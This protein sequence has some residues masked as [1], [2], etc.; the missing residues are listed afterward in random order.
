VRE[1]LLAGADKIVVTT[2]AVTNPALIT[3]ISERFGAQCVV[4]GIDYRQTESG[5][6]VWIRCGTESTGLDPVAHAVELVR[7]GA[8]E[9]F[10]NSIDRDG[11]MQGY[12]LDMAERVAR[13]VPVPVIVS[14]GAGNFMHLVE[15]LRDTGASAAACASLF[16]F[17][18]N[19]P[20][21]A[22]SYI[23]NVGM[24]MRVLK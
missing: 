10:L 20:I 2:A 21:R 5:P 4:A 8:G 16:H 24:P 1:L 7:L 9:L 14:G 22:R 18:D 12:D 11:A 3:E 23:R 15:V 19:N 13:A 17:G 6:R